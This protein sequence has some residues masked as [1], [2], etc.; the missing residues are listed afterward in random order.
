MLKT[1][2]IR[3]IEVVFKPHFNSFFLNSIDYA[4]SRKNFQILDQRT[5]ISIKIF[6]LKSFTKSW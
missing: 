3:Q 5:K 2:V 6:Q 1:V 4:D